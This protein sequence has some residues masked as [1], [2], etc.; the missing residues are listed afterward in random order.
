MIREVIVL[1]QGKPPGPDDPPVS[2]LDAA[3]PVYEGPAVAAE[4]GD[5]GWFVRPGRS[6]KFSSE[7]LRYRKQEVEEEDDK[8][9]ASAI[10]EAI[11][12]FT[13]Q[14]PGGTFNL[15][16]F[17][18]F[19]YCLLCSKNCTS[20]CMG[21]PPR[22]LPKV[23]NSRSI[24]PPSSIPGLD[25]GAS[26]PSISLATLTKTASNNKIIESFEHLVIYLVG[27]RRQ[28]KLPSLHLLR[29]TDSRPSPS[30]TRNVTPEATTE[31]FTNLLS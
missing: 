8:R 31:L 5:Q 22:K 6:K 30:P 26:L 27:K 14:G 3:Q 12:R 4:G 23:S 16:G 17:S 2:S 15:K 10:V 25:V 18:S 20:S 28:T 29:T 1:S 24:A 13:R 9:S 11:N 21:P 7:D 19:K